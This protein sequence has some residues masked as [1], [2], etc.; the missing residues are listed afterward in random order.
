MTSTTTEWG[1]ATLPEAGFAPDLEERFE[2]RSPS[3]GSAKPAW[4]GGRPQRTHL[5][6]ALSSWFGRG[7]G[8]PWAQSDLDRTHCTTCARLRKAS[9]DYCMGSPWPLYRCQ[10]RRRS[11][12][13]NSWSIRS[14]APILQGNLSRS[15]TRLTMTRGTEW[16][17]MTIPYTD[18]RNSEIA[19]DRAA[20]RYRYVLE[21][22][23]VEAPGLHW[24]YNGGA[25][26]LLLDRQ[27]T[28]R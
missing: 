6:R 3:W 23:V 26:A 24:T 4:R 17:E 28:R 1:T 5:L 25:T 9:S 8:R 20:D 7:S 11:S 27:P 10:Y 13:S 19:M 18:P 22:P 15:V 2:C 14:L 16:D 12:S 21:R